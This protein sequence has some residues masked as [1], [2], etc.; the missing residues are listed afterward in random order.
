MFSKYLRSYI[1]KRP[2]LSK[3]IYFFCKN[4]INAFDGENNGNIKTNGEF[5]VMKQL[6]PTS[7]IVFDIGA[8]VGS[9]TLLALSINPNLNV[10]CFEPCS[11]AYNKLSRNNFPS[12]VILNNTGISSKS[13]QTEIY[14]FEGK[15]PLNSLYQREGLENLNIQKPNK[16]ESITLE[17][18]N[19]YCTRNNIFK[20]DFIK[21]DVEGHELDVL[22][23]GRHLFEENRIQTIQ[24]EYGGCYIDAR[25]FLKDIFY[26]F[27][28]LNYDLFKIFPNEVKHVARYS[29]SLEN[30]QLQNWL[31]KQ[32]L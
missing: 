18:L 19:D 4:Y 22:N 7:K 17:T 10:H 16:T 1:S 21:I 28:D 12:N 32:R 11:D 20:I 14:L 27:K 13:N 9:W 25:V 2:K 6:L 26:F 3:K 30:F 23:G 31:A 8:N 15:S 5:R 24:F 29:Q